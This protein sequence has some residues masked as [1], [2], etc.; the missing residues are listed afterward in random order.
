MREILSVIFFFL[1]YWFDFCILD[2]DEW[3]VD[4]FKDEKFVDIVE[5]V[6]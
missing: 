1:N 6:L 5:D 2:E 3:G 4:I